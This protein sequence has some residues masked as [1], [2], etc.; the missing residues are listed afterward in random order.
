MLDRLREGKQEVERGIDKGAKGAE[1]QRD[2]KGHK[3][4]VGGRRRIGSGMR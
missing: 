1:R 4:R 3:W 2:A